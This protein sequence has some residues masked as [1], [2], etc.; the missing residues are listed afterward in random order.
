ML[1]FGIF[2]H[3]KV[4]LT[5]CVNFKLSFLFSPK[6]LQISLQQLSSNSFDFPIASVGFKTKYKTNG[7]S[8]KGYMEFKK[9]T[10]CKYRLQISI[11]LA[12]QKSN[13]YDN[14]LK[15]MEE[16]GY[17]IKLGKYLS[18]RHKEQ[19]EKGRFIR[20]KETTLGK[21]YTN[22]KIKERIKN[23]INKKFVKIDFD[24][25]TK[26]YKKVDNL[27]DLKI[28]KRYN[29]LKLMKYGQRSTI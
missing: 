21:D 14:F 3:L 1:S 29:L 20:A 2:K 19:G 6:L 5:N 24:S 8:Y 23:N 27:I 9:G 4:S 25:S 12:I 18:F 17:E 16:Y 10:S 28:I 7:K 11:D 22:E 26:A 13:S 15:T